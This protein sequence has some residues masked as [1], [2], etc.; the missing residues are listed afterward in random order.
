MDT[1]DIEGLVREALAGDQDSLARL[2]AKL[3]PVIQARIARTLKIGG[4]RNVRQ[5]V[6][7]LTQEVFLHL[8]CHG[9]LRSWKPERGLSLENFVGLVSKREALSFRRSH[10]RNPR[11]EVLVDTANLDVVDPKQGPEEAAAS[12]EQFCLLLERLQEELSPHGWHL[13]DLLYVQE[14]SLKE[15]MAA[16]GLSA[17]AVY[18]R[19]SR[20]RRL[21][22]RL[23]SELSEEP[24][25]ARKPQ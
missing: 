16:T 3:T 4:G 7:D 23:I 10:R 11:N 17:V 9:V 14:L 21:A 15:T 18:A 12:R 2:V 20:L 13:F 1:E 25:P 22:K 19:R 24:P 6:E 5:D 8:F